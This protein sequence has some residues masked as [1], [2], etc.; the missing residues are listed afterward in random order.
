MLCW[1]K[2]KAKKREKAIKSIPEE[3]EIMWFC[4]FSLGFRLPCSEQEL[5][6]DQE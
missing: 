6:S 4:F 2:C 5:K 3:G 1:G